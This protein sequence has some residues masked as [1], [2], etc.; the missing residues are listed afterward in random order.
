[1]VKPKIAIITNFFKL[2]SQR[3]N[4]QVNFDN[5]TK[6]F[7]RD[8][9][10][11]LAFYEVFINKSYKKLFIGKNIKPVTY[12]DIGA[13]NGDSTIFASKYRYIKNIISVEPHPDNFEVLTKNLKVNKVNATLLNMAV[14]NSKNVTMYVYKN[15]RQTGIH[16]NGVKR[17]KFI[18]K[19]ISLKKLVDRL[20]GKI[21][22]KCD[23]E[24]A[25]FDIFLKT[26]L[27]ILNKIDR[28]IVEYHSRD[29]LTNLVDR[30][31]D[32]GMKV[33]TTNNKFIEGFGYIY[34][35]R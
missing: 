29:K 2:L 20:N 23:T 17:K 32:S 16:T 5:S 34:A 31:H 26:P 24:G 19:G 15:K 25:E 7:M 22:V 27:R 6:F 30:F 21:F 3:A 9:Y 1:M 35:T 12:I 8:F 10:D 28:V 33:E 11:L 4:I 18:V 13:Y 14:A